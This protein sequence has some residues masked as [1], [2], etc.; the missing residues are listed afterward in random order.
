MGAALFTYY[1]TDGNNWCGKSE[2]F[3]A[4]CGSKVLDTNNLDSYI[5]HKNY[6]G[7]IQL[8]ELAEY[9]RNG[10]IVGVVQGR[11]EIG[12]RALG[13]R[14]ILADPGIDDMKNILNAKVKFREWY[15]PFEPVVQREKVSKYF[16]IDVRVD[17]TT[18]QLE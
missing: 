1:V 17:K 16:N 10:K 18:S 9:L 11:S 14:S 6:K 5:N 15:R 4:Y 3:S 12:P 7:E 8:V 13:N 2:T